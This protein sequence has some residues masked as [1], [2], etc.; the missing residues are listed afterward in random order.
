MR[1]RTNAKLIEFMNC[2]SKKIKQSIRETK[3][4]Q[5]EALRMEIKEYSMQ[6]SRV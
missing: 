5:R 6:S 3:Y 2:Q 1:L 4:I